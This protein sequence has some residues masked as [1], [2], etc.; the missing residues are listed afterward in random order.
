[1]TVIDRFAASLDSDEDPILQDVRAYI[2]WQVGRQT[3]EFE[4]TKNDDIDI[5]TYL[6]HLKLNGVR[7]DVLRQKT[8]SLAHFYEWVQQT[9]LVQSNPFAN[10]DFTRPFLTKSEIRRRRVFTADDPVQQELE[11]LQALNELATNLNQAHDLQT[12]L[13]T[14]TN[15]LAKMMALEAVWIFLFA[16]FYKQVVAARASLPHDVALAAACGLPP[17]L[18]Q[19]NRYFLCEPPDCSCQAMLRR[20]H[21]TRAVNVVECTRLQDATKAGGD[22]RGLF[23]HASTPLRTADR[24][25]GLINVATEEW[26]LFTAADLQFVSTVGAQVA[27]ALERARLFDL[28]QQHQA[29]LERELEMARQ[30]QASLLLDELP[31]I[32]G[33]SVAVYWQAAREM[34]GDFYDIIPLG[35]GRFA[36][37]MADVSDKGAPA[38]L[39]MAMAHSLIRDNCRRISSPAEMLHFVNA[40]IME[41]DSSDMFVTVFYGV[42]DSNSNQLIYANAGHD[43]PLLHR[44]GEAIACLMPTGP[45]IGVLQDMTLSETTIEI[46]PGDR[47]LTY[48]DGVTDALNEH[49]E[50]YGRKRLTKMLQTVATDT[51]EIGLEQILHDL[52]SF[53]DDTAQYDDI[54]ML[55]LVADLDSSCVDD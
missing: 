45:L 12:V 14:T 41:R 55:M 23:F 30:V 5:R 33:F 48:T 50:E 9:G 53:I 34:A 13:Q 25:F 52:N 11:R 7:Q 39:Y 21:L 20:G 1:M 16:D 31:E 37:V 3:K 47:I 49:S 28:T 2:N 38:A 17:S 29:R 19:D 44:Q 51:A 42:L 46:N 8:N 40:A 6:L 24:V 32:P 54:T 35:N 10:F 4:P 43:P 27:V 26:Q 18:E 36:L 15:T 22:S